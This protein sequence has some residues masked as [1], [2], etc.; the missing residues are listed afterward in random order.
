MVQT[1]LRRQLGTFNDERPHP[2]LGDNA[3]SPDTREKVMTRWRLGLPLVTASL[4][5]LR[6]VYAYTHR[7]KH[8]CGGS[9]NTDWLGTIGQ[10]LPQETTK[11]T[12]RFAV[13]IWF[14]LRCI[15]LCILRP[16]HRTSGPSSSTWTQRL[17]LFVHRQSFGQS[18]CLV[19]DT[20]YPLRPA[21]VPIGRSIFIRETCFGTGT[22]R[23]VGPM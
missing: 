4:D 10:R 23:T 20:R 21:N 3:Y 5:A 14:A 19:S 1:Q 16:T 12:E 18:S 13:N 15:G 11:S 8:A 9:S 2:S 17:H 6:E 22:I 7:T